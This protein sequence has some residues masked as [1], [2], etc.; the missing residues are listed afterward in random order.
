M[1]KLL[2]MTTTLLLVAT[3][4]ALAQ[5]ADNPQAKLDKLLS[6]ASKLSAAPAVRKQAAPAKLRTPASIMEYLFPA[7][8]MGGAAPMA[9]RQA[10]AQQGTSGVQLPSEISSAAAAQQAKASAPANTTPVITPAA[11]GTEPAASPIK[12]AIP[13]K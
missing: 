12:P 13:K 5:Q 1:H 4:T 6:E 3:G 2:S 9:A 7:R 10:N 11:Q 8:S